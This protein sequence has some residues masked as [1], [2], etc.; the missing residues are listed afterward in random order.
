MKVDR[1]LVAG[2]D[3]SRIP[4]A[5]HRIVQ[6]SGAGVQCEGEVEVTEVETENFEKAHGGG[7]FP[8]EGKCE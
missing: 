8:S 4:A 6:A 3:N 2:Q 5:E 7:M 1:S